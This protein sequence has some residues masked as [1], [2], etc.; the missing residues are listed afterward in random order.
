MGVDCAPE[1]YYKNKRYAIKDQAAALETKEYIEFLIDAVNKYNMLIVED[2]LHE[3]DFDGW[4]T[5]TKEIGAQT[6]I[7]ADDFIAGN[8]ERLKR[9]ADKR[10]C[11][12]VLVK[13]NQLGTISEMLKFIATVREVDM[14]LVVSHR[15]GETTDATIADLGV[16]IQADFVKFGSP[17]RGERIVKYNRL[18]EI[19]SLIAEHGNL[20]NLSASPIEEA[21]KQKTSQ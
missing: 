7:V 8:T 6:Y 3:E 13:F 12:A 5:I 4:T 14:K 16:G 9:A 17:A 15:M 1:Y 11:N 20:T 2:P 18:L 19:E 10:A 21:Q